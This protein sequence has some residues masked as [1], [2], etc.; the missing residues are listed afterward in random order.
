[1]HGR[2]ITNRLAPVSMHMYRAKYMYWQRCYNSRRPR[3]TTMPIQ[4]GTLENPGMVGLDSRHSKISRSPLN[5]GTLGPEDPYR[6]RPVDF[7]LG[8][9]VLI[10]V[11]QRCC[12]HLRS[13]AHFRFASLLL[14][15]FFSFLSLA[16]SFIYPAPPKRLLPCIILL[17]SI[18]RSAH[19]CL[20]SSTETEL[21]PPNMSDQ[22]KPM[23]ADELLKHP[24]YEHTIWK[25]KP[26]QKGKFP[27]A[28]DRG[29]PIN[30]AYEVHGHGD[31]HV[32]FIMGLG[33]MKYAWQ[34]AIKDLAHKQADRYTLL[35]FDNRGIG[36][37]DKPFFRY[38]TSEMAKDTVEL[39]DHLG[40]SGKRQLH[41]VGVSMGG[42]IAQ[43]VAVQIP[44]R[45]CTLSLV[46]TAAG[47]FRTTGFLENL[48]NRANLFIP[49]SLDQQIA[50]VKANLY[51]SNWLDQPDVL[52]H[53][54]KPFPTNGDRFAANELWKRSHPE[55]FTKGGFILQAIAA[56]W[57]YKSPEDL[58]RLA[59]DVGKKR[60]MVVH[61]T[62]DRMLTFPHGVVLWRGLEKGEGKTGTE[63]WLGLEQE[64]DVWEEGEV[65]KRFIEGQGHVVPIEMREEFTGWLEA[66]FQRGKELNEKEGI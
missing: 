32:V 33:G 12:D 16:V 18:P 51:T 50:N 60:I 28:K 45:I 26:S 2:R 7:Q 47:L 62:K 55:Y 34:R 11:I 15:L 10:L 27:V 4:T 49:K 40:W 13:Q 29:G 24:E 42:M 37:S 64:S 48:Y 1:M 38:S 59:Q 9:L 54:V 22:H 65:E 3:V 58:H 35:A 20:N 17:S 57:H 36:E 56:G 30:I 19:C 14:I 46:S 44:D 63:N 25:L 8:P 39:I 43:E 21:A 66:L 6:H 23:T 52:E 41:V 5:P 53:T 61:G 31:T